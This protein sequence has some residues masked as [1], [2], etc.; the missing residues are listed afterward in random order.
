MTRRQTQISLELPIRKRYGYRFLKPEHIEFLTDLETLNMWAGKSLAKRCVLFHRH[1]GNHRINPTLLRKVYHLHKIKRK[2]IK[3]TKPLKPDK[4][5][6]YE[7]WRQ[8]VKHRI[9]ELKG[10]GYRI[11]YLDECGLTTKT[12]MMNDFTQ[13]NTHHRIPMELVS[14]PV[15]S[16]V[17]AIS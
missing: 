12:I 16:L 5:D 10:N 9:A 15:Y 6:H 8:G 14:Q 4:E 13:L 7:E 17:L 11:I 1:F 3:L 2:R